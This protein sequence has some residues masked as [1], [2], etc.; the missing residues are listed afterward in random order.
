MSSRSICR[1]L[2]LHKKLHYEFSI[3]LQVDGAAPAVAIA[4][5]M[6]HPFAVVIWRPFCSDRVSRVAL[7]RR[8]SCSMISKHRDVNG[9]SKPW[10]FTCFQLSLRRLLLCPFFR[11]VLSSSPPFPSPTSSSFSLRSMD[12]RSGTCAS[13]MGLCDDR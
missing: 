13:S 8:R 3:H 9:V 6:T 10:R 2:Q 1:W 7:L 11:V 12:Q 4:K 5:V